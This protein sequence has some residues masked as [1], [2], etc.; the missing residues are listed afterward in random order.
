MANAVVTLR[1]M[2]EGVEVNLDKVTKEAESAIDK[3]VG[4]HMQKVIEV[5]PVAFGLKAVEI[6]FMM[7]EKLGSPDTVADL[8]GNIDGVQSAEVT[9]VTRALG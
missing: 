9:N 4:K 5:T 7:D 6:Q 8:I 3:F 2:P 1:I